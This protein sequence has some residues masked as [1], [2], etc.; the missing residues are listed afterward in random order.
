MSWVEKLYTTYENCESMIGK[1]EANGKT[2]LLPIAHST[3]NAQL[4][5]TLDIG[6]NFQS[7]RALDKQDTVTLIPV[8]ENSASRSSGVEPHPLFDKLQYISGDYTEFVDNGKGKEFFRKIHKAVGG[9]VQFV[10]SQ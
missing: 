2:P 6:G 3:Q 4:E 7:A 9:L 10:F 1:V 5:V 8:T